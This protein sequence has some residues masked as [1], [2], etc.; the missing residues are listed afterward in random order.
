GLPS[1]PVQKVRS[2]W[3][4][5]GDWRAMIR[6]FTEFTLDDADSLFERL[7]RWHKPG[8][9]H[10]FFAFLT[11]LMGLRLF[12]TTNFDNFLER[13]LTEQGIDHRVFG[14]EHGDNLPHE[15]L[16]RETV[17]VIKLHGDTHQ[18]LVDEKLD[19][20]PSPEY[21]KRL[22]ACMPKRPILMVM[23]CGGND[24]RILQVVT[25][26]AEAH[27]KANAQH[28]GAAGKIPSVIWLHFEHPRNEPRTLANELG[29][30]IMHAR[31]TNP[32]FFLSHLYAC[33]RSQHP[34]S[35]VPYQTHLPQ[36]IA[37]LAPG[38]STAAS[39][40][41][42]RNARQNVFIYEQRSASA[43]GERV[44]ASQVMADFVYTRKTEHHCTPIWINLEA[45]HSVGAVVQQIVEQ[46]RVHDTFVSPFDVPSRAVDP[47]GTAI[48]LTVERLLHLLRRGRYVLAFDALEAF[49]WPPTAHHGAS[50]EQE[51]APETERLF[52]LLEALMT[53]R[54]L[55]S[56]IG[57]VI[58]AS[59]DLPRRRGDPGDRS[60]L[61][62]RF[63]ALV[64]HATGDD[65]TAPPDSE[66]RS[67]R[68]RTALSDHEFVVSCF[69][70][71]RSL[72]SLSSVFF[73][74]FGDESATT[75]AKLDE[76]TDAG[77]LVPIEGGFFRMRRGERDEM[78]N[79]RAL[80]TGTD[81]VKRALAGPAASR[82]ALIAKCYALAS[83]HGL[84]A[85]CYYSDSYLHSLDPWIF[86]EY[87]YHRLS[88]IRYITKLVVLLEAVAPDAL[89]HTLDVVIPPK[90]VIKDEHRNRAYTLR[91][92]LAYVGPERASLLQ[93][94]KHALDQAHVHLL[95]GLPASQLEAWCKG[96]LD[97]NFSFRIDAEDGILELARCRVMKA[98]YGSELAD[99]AE[100]AED[101]SGIFWSLLGLLRKSLFQQGRNREASDVAW[102]QLAQNAAQVQRASA[103][104]H[105]APP[106]HAADRVLGWLCETDAAR[107]LD[108]RARPGAI[109]GGDAHEECVQNLLDVLACRPDARD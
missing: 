71:P 82:M 8:R 1:L 65:W 32:G 101:V 39:I 46:C 54:Q 59:F 99:T 18:L 93:A 69:R 60:E 108:D 80:E 58:C 96:V 28:R 57:V 72:V 56:D 61:L 4:M 83:T 31:V 105:D 109:G 44:A 106:R 17:S 90:S 85:R 98:R 16:V 86:F 24:S 104:P 30:E 107:G 94:L 19:Y 53:H 42:Y 11:R 77:C 29:D 63:A 68:A 40:A 34:A 78:Y 55:Q 47:D 73:D 36:P 14:V 51:S 87:F 95:R 5:L 20:P 9:S 37:P 81:D 91:E 6:E 76:L 35:R 66:R 50:G 67:A 103:T 23:G 22:R 89:D 100:L 25:D 45:H 27:R 33:L 64:K 48:A 7:Y 15:S 97:D 2:T 88:S 43:A 84:V 75:S 21:L 52:A 38:T 79:E 70:R 10:H 13:A 41:T 74:I 92:I 26:H 3:Q 49:P 12:L 102:V 62:A